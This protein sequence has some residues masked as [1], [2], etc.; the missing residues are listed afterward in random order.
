MRFECAV[1]KYLAK[2]ISAKFGVIYKTI[3]CRFNSILSLVARHFTD[4]HDRNVNNYILINEYLGL[5]FDK[6]PMLK[7]LKR[8]ITLKK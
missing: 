5:Q 3:L 4:K 6:V 2:W 7:V 8:K 1:V